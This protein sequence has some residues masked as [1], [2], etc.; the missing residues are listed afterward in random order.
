M[1]VFFLGIFPLV[2]FMW[3]TQKLNVGITQMGIQLT[4]GFLFLY[5]SLRLCQCG[6]VGVAW[7]TG[8]SLACRG[9]WFDPQH[10]KQ[11][12]KPVCQ[13]HVCWI[14]FKRNSRGPS[15]GLLRLLSC[16]LSLYLTPRAFRISLLDWC[17]L[18][19]HS[20]PSQTFPLYAP[21]N[22]KRPAKLQLGSRHY[23]FW[24]HNLCG[25][26]LTILWDARHFRKC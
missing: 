2:D 17:K 5:S 16:H 12:Q 24:K 18:S 9:S 7:S 19:S 20:R 6:T 21:C 22:L 10:C 15:A 13:G 4:L 25:N 1:H 11:T 26:E 3:L 14:Q 23:Y 8:A